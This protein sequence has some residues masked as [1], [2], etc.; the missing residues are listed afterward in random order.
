MGAFEALLA[1]LER[2]SEIAFDPEAD[3]FYRYQE[4]VCLIQVTVEEEDYLVDPLSG[5][6]VRPIVL[7]YSPGGLAE[8]SLIALS[9]GIET[10]FVA[11]H[12]IVR[13]GLIVIAAPLVFRIFGGREAPD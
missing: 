7:A 10:A 4:R 9:L 5:I 2:A 13:I 12:H 1:K 8:M 11:T 6:D 3:S